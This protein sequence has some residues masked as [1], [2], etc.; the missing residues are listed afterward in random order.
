MSYG[1]VN[2]LTHTAEV[3]LTE[4]QRNAI[5]RLKRKHRAQDVKEGLVK[6]MTDYS[7]DEDIEISINELEEFGGAL[8]D[9]FRREDVPKLE[10]YLR[11]HFKEFRHTYSAPVEQVTC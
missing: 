7:S 11:N 4:E 10:Q 9:I 1:Q 3:V 2:I 6:E 8:W 5:K